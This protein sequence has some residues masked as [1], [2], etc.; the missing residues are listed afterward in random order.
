[1]GVGTECA[2]SFH[3]ILQRT[4][5]AHQVT[6]ANLL[7]LLKAASDVAG[8]KFPRGHDLVATTS[9]T[10]MVT[11]SLVQSLEQL[12]CSDGL[13][14]HTLLPLAGVLSPRA[15]SAFH[16]TQRWCPICIDPANEDRYGMLAW[17][18]RSVKRCPLHGIP[19]ATSCPQC[20]RGQTYR[21]MLIVRPYCNRCGAPLWRACNRNIVGDIGYDAWAERQILELVS[22]LSTPGR[23]RA[24]ESWLSDNAELLGELGRDAIGKFKGP[25][26]RQVALLRRLPQRGLQ[27]NTLLWLAANHSTR[28]VDL[29]LR[30]KEVLTG[31]FPNLEPIPR[32]IPKR[33]MRVA[34]QWALYREAI[35]KLLDAGGETYLPAQTTL[36]ALFRI[37]VPWSKDPILANRYTNARLRSPWPMRGSAA[38]AHDRLFLME[39]IE[40]AE[41]DYVNDIN[42]VWI[43][44]RRRI[45]VPD[46]LRRQISYAAELI[47]GV[48]GRTI[49]L[50]PVN[51][52]LPKGSFRKG[53]S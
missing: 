9:G 8:L 28:L 7:L 3:S 20:Y 25:E 17:L 21:A 38:G 15:N 35:M 29:I 50:N 22:F 24:S 26:A 18:L 27:L 39:V 5:S 43:L 11:R 48:I 46:N 33:R 30:P 42:I 44:S 16:R 36:A 47:R 19:L 23:A 2:E 6:L 40:G 32:A 14:S 49:S 52:G 1:M 53:S 41:G 37:A 34:S 4:A 10:G 12:G 31:V 13:E 51:L 45:E